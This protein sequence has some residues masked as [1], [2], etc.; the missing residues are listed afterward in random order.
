MDC[1]ICGNGVNNQSYEAKEMQLGTRDVFTYFQC[2]SCQCLQ[3]ADIPE[4]LSDYYPREYYSFNISPETFY[5]GLK[6]KFKKLR[7]SST[8]L[9]KNQLISTLFP[10]KTYDLVAQTGVQPQSKIL[11]VGCGT[12][13]FL[14]AM[15]EV[16]F[17]HVQGIDP[18]IAQDIS[19]ANGLNIYKK[20]IHEMTSKSWDL[21]MYHH[22]FEHVPDPLEHLQKVKTLLSPEGVCMI[23]IPT[24]SSYAWEHYRTNWFQLDAPRHIFLHSVESIQILA[25][26]AGL[27]L[28]DTI[29]DSEDLQFIA[30]EKYVKDITLN[31]RTYKGLTGKIRKKLDKWKYRKK[32]KQLN[33]EK[34]GDQAAFFLRLR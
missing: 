12:G 32:A 2:Q 23:R 14:Y 5:Q 27:E 18:F 25:E 19:Y 21:I 13:Y 7:Y 30:S 4:N 9:H 24:A 29:Y 26:K 16:G 28:F 33:A 6:G 8:L 15:A 20:S 1:R 31:E 11:D 34:R 17:K 3:I 10:V 22:S